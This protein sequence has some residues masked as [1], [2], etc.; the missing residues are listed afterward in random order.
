VEAEIIMKTVIPLPTG[1]LLPIQEVHGDLNLTGEQHDTLLMAGEELFERTMMSV[2]QENVDED[3]YGL[4]LAVNGYLFNLMKINSI[5]S[6]W[7][8]TWTCARIIENPTNKKRVQCSHQNKFTFNA[9][10]FEY[11]EIPA[12][13]KYPRYTWSDPEGKEI[14]FYVKA[15]STAQEFEVLDFFLEQPGITRKNLHEDEKL[16]F[17]YF[18]RRW[19]TGLVIEGDAYTDMKPEDKQRF[20]NEHRVMAKDIQSSYKDL[21]YLDSLGHDFKPVQ[22]T[23]EECGESNSLHIPFQWG[24]LGMV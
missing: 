10:G 4:P 5:T 18:K 12:K 21:R 9:S 8:S 1:H 17:K 24:L 20:L 16:L 3:V 14:S 11:R 2:I 7:T 6:Q 19:V 23:C 15:L 13:F 22:V